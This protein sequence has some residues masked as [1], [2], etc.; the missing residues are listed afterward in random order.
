MLTYISWMPIVPTGSLFTWILAGIFTTFFFNNLCWQRH[1][2]LTSSALN[3]GFYLCWL[4]IGG[5]LAQYGIVFPSWWG[6]GGIHNDGCPLALLNTTG[7][8]VSFQN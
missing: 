5:P 6:D 7:F 4:I 1:V 8:S 3:G 2:Y